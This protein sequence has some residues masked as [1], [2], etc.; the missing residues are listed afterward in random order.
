MQVEEDTTQTRLNA[1]SSCHSALRRVDVF[2]VRPQEPTLAGALLTVGVIIAWLV[3]L[4]FAATHFANPPTKLTSIVRWT[5]MSS[6][7]SRFGNG[8]PRFTAR[9]KC[10]AS[11]GCMVWQAYSTATLRSRLCAEALPPAACSLLAFGEVK[12]T[13]FCYSDVPGDGLRGGC[14]GSGDCLELWNVNVME[15]DQPYATPMGF[16][17]AL[18]LGAS[19]LSCVH[20]TN[21]TDASALGA[22]RIEWFPQV[23]PA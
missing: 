18:P 2:Q 11:R 3:S 15:R 21:R 20:T 13:E 9:L 23:P 1:T 12:A 19:E 17:N 4:G 14:L 7:A 8:A 6:P 10:S 16:W 5:S 22:V